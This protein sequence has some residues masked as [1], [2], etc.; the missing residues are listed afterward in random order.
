MKKVNKNKSKALPIT[1]EER[2]RKF[3]WGTD[4]LFARGRYLTTSA[5]W[6]YVVIRSFQNQPTFPDYEAIMERG[7]MTRATIAKGL[8]ELEHWGYIARARTYG[9]AN[10]YEFRSPV[11]INRGTGEDQ[12]HPTLAQAKEYVKTQKRLRLLKSLS[13]LGK[14]IQAKRHSGDQI[15]KNW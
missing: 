6:L 12:Y 9:K 1:D 14:A 8:R 10:V 3:V 7:G 13:K 4:D 5:K 11:V 2:M 15:Y